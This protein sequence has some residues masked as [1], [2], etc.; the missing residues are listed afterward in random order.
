MFDVQRGGDLFTEVT[1]MFDPEG[2]RTYRY[3]L[4]H[5]WD[6]RPPPTR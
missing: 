2:S 5:R 4:I 1:A 6:T 3:V